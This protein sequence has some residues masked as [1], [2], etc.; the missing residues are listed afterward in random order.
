MEMH[1]FHSANPVSFRENYASD[2]KKASDLVEQAKFDGY[3]LRHGGD[4]CSLHFAAGCG[5]LEVCMQLLHR[6]G[7][8]NFTTDSS[9][10]TPLF[11]AVQSGLRSTVGLLLQHGAD[12]VHKDSQGQTPL[13][14]CAAKGLPQTCS[15][16][17]GTRS[18]ESFGLEVRSCRG[19][20]PLH[21][22]ARH[23]HTEVI[24][25]LLAATA[26]PSAVTLQGRT[27]LHLAAMAGHSSAVE[28][29][30]EAAGPLVDPAALF[31]LADV[32]GMRALDYALERGLPEAALV[33]SGE[34]CAQERIRHR[35][36]QLFEPP[37]RASLNVS[38][39]NAWLE[40]SRPEIL[41]VNRS[42]LHLACRIVDALGLVEGYTIEVSQS[43]HGR[44]MEEDEDACGSIAS[45]SFRRG[46]KQKPIDNVE[47][48]L[49]RHSEGKSVWACGAHYA[50]RVVGAVAPHLAKHSECPLSTIRSPWTI[51]TWLPALSAEGGRTRKHR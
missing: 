19:L 4:P 13:H 31:A 5:C 33:L 35:W 1:Y 47:F 24:D 50:F 46:A 42:A 51:P 36:K 16:L 11:W 23:G 48:R 44:H 8:L 17:L 20:S 7:R 12:A 45:V 38:M 9:G 2:V 34:E 29:L 18:V 22:A 28:R 25:C 15:L 49:P 40:I 37:C 14:L 39:C 32:E 41:A 6:C 3:A 43:V 21:V 10:Q 30:L 27:P 26:D